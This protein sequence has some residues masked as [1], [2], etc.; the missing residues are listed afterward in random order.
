MPAFLILPAGAPC[1]VPTNRNFLH[2]NLLVNGDTVLRA[3]AT[4]LRTV[5]TRNTPFDRF[6]AGDDNGL[7]GCSPAP[8]VRLGAAP[9]RDRKAVPD[10]RIPV[11]QLVRM[12]LLIRLD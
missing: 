8:A 3:M 12:E 5:V 2:N 9:A 6:L 1:L 11:L 10:V 7:T 4:F